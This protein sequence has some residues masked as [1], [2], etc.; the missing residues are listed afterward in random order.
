MNGLQKVGAATQRFL[1]DN[2]D[3]SFLVY[4]G[5]M[6]FDKELNVVAT[7]AL[8]VQGGE[9]I[10]VRFKKEPKVL[11]HKYH[12]EL[13][14]ASSGTRYVDTNA[15]MK[16]AGAFQYAFLSPGEFRSDDFNNT[17]G[18]FVFMLRGETSDDDGKVL[19]F[20]IAGGDEVGETRRGGGAKIESYI[21]VCISD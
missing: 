7:N 2:D 15:S 3:S 4:G 20:L 18:G 13:A 10:A 19:A 21:K 6:Y 5:Y 16:M 12:M 14:N 11:K 8:N 1:G 17:D 9:G